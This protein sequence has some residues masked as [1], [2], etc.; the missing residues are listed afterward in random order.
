M[1]ID[2]IVRQLAPPSEGEATVRLL[3]IDDYGIVVYFDGDDADLPI[4]LREGVANLVSTGRA[5][6]HKLRLP[7]GVMRQFVVMTGSGNQAT[8]RATRKYSLRR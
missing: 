6:A 7:G 5:R 4:L 8:S 3:M 1:N 2:G